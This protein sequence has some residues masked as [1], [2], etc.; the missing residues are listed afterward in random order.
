[1]NDAA[2]GPDEIQCQVA[3]SLDAIEADGRE[4]IWIQRRSRADVLA[5]AARVAWRVGEGERLPLA[6]RTVAVKGNVDVA[7]IRTTAG[8]PE[9]GEV[10]ARSAPAVAALEAAGAVVVGVTNLDQF[11]TGLVGTRSPYGVCPNAWWPERISG[12]SSSGSATAVAAGLVDLGVGTDT[13]GSGRIPAAAHGIAGIKPTRGRL[14]TAG[15]V[16]ACRSLDCLSVFAVDVELADLAVRIAA[17]ARPESVDDDPWF[18][19]GPNPLPAALAGTVRIGVPKL[20]AEAF[21]GVAAG[22]DVFR[23]AVDELTVAVE[24]VPGRSVREVP[25]DIESFVAA[26]RLLYD[27]AF[28][29]ERYA[30]VGDFV[31]AGVGTF[32]PTV[33]SIIE[34]SADLP[35]WR[36]A[37]DL[38]ELRR[39]AALTAPVWADIDVLVVPSAPRLPT[40]AEVVADP[41]GLNSMLGTYTNFVNLLDLAAVTV[42]VWAA[43]GVSGHDPVAEPPPSLTLVGPAWSDATLVSLAARLPSGTPATRRS[44]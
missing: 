17:G 36:Y 18:R 29:A 23:A 1:M 43:A 20:T 33:R 30:A 26:G 24:G 7:G 14:T 44:S 5:D 25:V 27:G 22:P 38:G 8:C 28:V 9:F 19:P 6:G 12:G 42:P 39:L 16:P 13:A 21:D 37:E 35:A 32:D 31:A 34:A 40:V 11:A 15:V 3:R 4:G 10:A 41:I 2:V